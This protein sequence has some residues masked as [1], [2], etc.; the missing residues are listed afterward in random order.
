MNSNEFCDS[1]NLT[2]IVNAP[3]RPNLKT[4]S[5]STLIDLI[6]TNEPHKYTHVGIFPDDVGDH[7]AVVTIRNCKVPKSKPWLI[8]KSSLKNF[9]TQGF[10]HDVFCM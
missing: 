3:T 4:P 5:K 6:L 10:L 9:D 2:R 1:V 7:C 8:R